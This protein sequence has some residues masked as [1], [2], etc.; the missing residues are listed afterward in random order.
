MHFARKPCEG[1]HPEVTSRLPQGHNVRPRS[2]WP[3]QRRLI[4]R[5]LKRKWSP[6]ARLLRIPT[7]LF[8]PA[9]AKKVG[10]PAAH[11]TPTF[12][13]SACQKSRI[14][15][16]AFSSDASWFDPEDSAKRRFTEKPPLPTNHHH[17]AFQSACWDTAV[18][19]CLLPLH[20]TSAT[21]PPFTRR[22]TRGSLTT[23]TFIR[24]LAPSPWEAPVS[25][26]ASVPLADRTLMLLTSK[27]S[28]PRGKPTAFFLVRYATT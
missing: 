14:A 8:W 19:P 21:L 13:A 7:R 5:P 28:E 26:L 4:E 25:L 17:Q 11:P 24:R 3:M 1:I 16:C 2:N 27:S 23:A 20:A 6:R 9:P 15:C 22:P 12:L 10:S 18:R